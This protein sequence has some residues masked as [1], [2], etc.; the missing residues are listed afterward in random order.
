MKRGDIA[1]I[2]G[3]LLVG[4]MLLFPWTRRETA[5]RVTVYAA[6]RPVYTC[7]LED[8]AAYTW[9][10]GDRFVRVEVAGGKV[11]VAD[12]SCPDRDCV[13]RGPQSRS[14]ASIIC[15]PN[16]VSVVLSG[17]AGADE[18]DAVLY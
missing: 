15:L 5:A 2:A 13:H 18:V 10:D 14:G 16:R 7:A 11:W 9:R 6:G 3:L 8:T 12:A 4:V 1:L 17:E